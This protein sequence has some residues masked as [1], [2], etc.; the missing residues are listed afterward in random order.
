MPYSCAI[1]F[2]WAEHFEEGVRATAAR[3]KTQSSEEETSK[4]GE[5]QAVLD[6]GVVDSF[7]GDGGSIMRRLFR[8]DP[9][10]SENPKPYT[11]ETFVE[12]G[13]SDE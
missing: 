6:R 13:S 7:G 1:D 3:A 4:G 10:T 9:V 8:K 2:R 11:P 12:E 5:F